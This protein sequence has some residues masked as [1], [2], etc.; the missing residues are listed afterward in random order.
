MPLR[1]DECL[2]R[3][4][5]LPQ[6]HRVREHACL[7]QPHRSPDRAKLAPHPGAV[8][9]RHDGENASAVQ[10]PDQEQAAQGSRRFLQVR[11]GDAD[12]PVIVDVVGD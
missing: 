8:F 12:Y 6:I 7:C 3:I 5:L 1:D 10:W 11:S 4:R 9:V 2:V